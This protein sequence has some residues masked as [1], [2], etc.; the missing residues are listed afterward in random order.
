MCVP[1]DAVSRWVGQLGDDLHGR[2]AR[3]GLVEPRRRESVEAWL[4]LYVAEKKHVLK[5]VSL[6]KI[7]QTVAKLKPHFANLSVRDLTRADA[8][9]WRKHLQEEGL[10][11]ATVRTHAGNAK[12]IFQEA[13]ERQL[14]VVNPFAALPSGSTP[15]QETRYVTPDDI[16]RVINVAPGTQW[17][18]LLGLARYTG[19]RIPSESHR[20]TRLDVDLDKGQLTVRSP[21]TEHHRG[22]EW[23]LVPIQPA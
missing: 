16:D 22:H 18:L 6:K 9:A 2:L 23:C 20:L 8:A 11:E 1:P 17:P 12:A 19:L 15:S 21:K 7:E 10:R 14:T 4:A 3:V 5:P 13:V